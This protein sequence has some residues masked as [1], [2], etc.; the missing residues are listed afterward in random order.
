M[1]KSSFML[2]AHSQGPV[3]TETLFFPDSFPSFATW[4]EGEVSA[5]LIWVDKVPSCFRCAVNSYWHKAATFCIKQPLSAYSANARMSSPW[6]LSKCNMAVPGKLWN[7]NKKPQSVCKLS[8]R[9]DAYEKGPGDFE[10]LVREGSVQPKSPLSSHK[11]S[12][13]IYTVVIPDQAS[14]HKR[15]VFIFS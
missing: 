2:I 7:R 14:N 10:V 6:P 15:D 9:P 1:N 8:Q 4:D 12:D 13:R 11:S 3:F 5:K